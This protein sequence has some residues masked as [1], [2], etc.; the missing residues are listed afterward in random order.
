ML[1]LHS[2]D[3]VFVFHFLLLWGFVYGNQHFSISDI[4]WT[5]LADASSTLRLLNVCCLLSC[6]LIEHHWETIRFMS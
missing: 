1:M 4:T 6:G 2:Q 5:N 3:N